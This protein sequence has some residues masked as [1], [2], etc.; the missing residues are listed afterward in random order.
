MGDDVGDTRIRVILRLRPP[1]KQEDGWFR[2]GEFKPM[3]RDAGMTPN[4]DKLIIQDATGKESLF[5]KVFRGDCKQ[6]AIFRE[7]ALPTLENVFKGYCGA[8][9]AYGQTGTG[10]THTMQG[11][12]RSLDGDERGIIPRCADYIFARA[13]KETSYR[14]DITIGMVQIYLD[15]L[16][17]LFQPEAPEMNITPD[18]ERVEMPGLTEKSVGSTA[19]FMKLYYYGEAHRVTRATL[20]NPTSSRG[21]AA[22]IVNIRMEPKDVSLATKVGKLVLVD[23]AGYERFALTGITTGI[24][25]EE[26]KK[27]NASLL[28][29]G[30]VVNSLADRQKHVP[31]RN[32][33]LT[34]LLRDCLGGTSKSTIVLTV[35][36]CDKY[37]QETS[38]TLYF[39]WRAMAVKVDARIREVYDPTKYIAL[40]KEKIAEC[41]RTMQRMVKFMKDRGIFD[42]Y[43]KA[44]GVPDIPDASAFD[45]NDEE[46]EILA[47]MTRQV[48]GSGL[49]RGG[50]GGGAAMMSAGEMM[51]DVLDDDAAAPAN[52]RKVRQEWNQELVEQQRAAEKELEVLRLRHLQDLEEARRAGASEDVLSRL[53]AEHDDELSLMREQNQALRQEIL[54]QKAKEEAKALL[55]GAVEEKHKEISTSVKTNAVKQDDAR[56][57]EMVAHLQET[58][59]NKDEVLVRLFDL[60][61]LR[62]AELKD[63]EQNVGAIAAAMAPADAGDATSLK[64]E[65]QRL[66]GELQR[67]DQHI[68]ALKGLI[69]GAGGTPPGGASPPARTSPPPAGGSGM[70]SPVRI[71]A[72]A[73]ASHGGVQTRPLSPASSGSGP[74]VRQ[75]A[76]GTS[77]STTRYSPGGVPGAPA[78]TSITISTTT[79]MTS[80]AR[81]GP[82]GPA[83]GRPAG[84]SSPPPQGYSGQYSR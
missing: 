12:D 63:L 22:L 11:Y 27:I 56:I 60:I 5:D 67:K 80:P 81:A 74:V 70:T 18:T 75:L 29:L 33:K 52:V 50:G 71:A 54:R 55:T 57:G 53:R 69:S 24:A 39:G 77:V 16:Q 26:A 28:A 2:T 1:N 13:A 47:A 19:E 40:L 20:M 7:S 8:I 10:K 42:A 4:A 34:R 64:A 49:A 32:A 23:L 66:K 43:T 76:P 17:D 31:Y 44:Y 84:Y 6:V 78:G 68:E 25:A 3:F 51:M 15:K 30:A 35:G 83:Y 62:E 36:P 65:N 79:G 82:P 41:S 45:E 21:H 58:C 73:S 46:N 61:C 14:F 9:M 59:E 48:S 38:G 37:K 72:S